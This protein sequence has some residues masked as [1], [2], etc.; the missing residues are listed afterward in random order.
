M[1]LSIDATGDASLE[2]NT[3]GKSVYLPARQTD[4]KGEAANYTLIY[5]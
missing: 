4:E 1:R 5:E 3:E 2:R